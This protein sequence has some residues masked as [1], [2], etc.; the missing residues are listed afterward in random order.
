MMNI[1]SVC[2]TNERRDGIPGLKICHPDATAMLNG[3]PDI[4]KIREQETPEEHLPKRFWTPSERGSSQ[5]AQ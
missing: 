2:S 5:A 4:E 1:S 3:E